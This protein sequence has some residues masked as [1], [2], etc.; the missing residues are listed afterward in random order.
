MT[1]RPERSDAIGRGPS[2][3]LLTRSLYP[4][5]REKLRPEE[6]LLFYRNALWIFMADQCV[7]NDGTNAS[8][9][10]RH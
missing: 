1:C 10:R 7:T 4:S 9:R 2:T 8:Y 3:T 5:D 6:V